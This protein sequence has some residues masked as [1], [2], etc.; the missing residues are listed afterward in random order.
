MKDEKVWRKS[1][2]A[3]LAN[4]DPTSSKQS[5]GEN[6]IDC[7]NHADEA[8]ARYR[9]RF[10][11]TLADGPSVFVG[12]QVLCLTCSTPAASHPHAHC[13]GFR[14]SEPERPA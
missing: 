3:L 7:A 8:L 9:K 11:I 12:G 1:F 14:P 4:I 10:P 13:A 2:L 6:I 5:V